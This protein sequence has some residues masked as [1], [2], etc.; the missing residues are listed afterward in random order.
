[1]TTTLAERLGHSP[2]DK[3]VIVSCDDLGA[4]HV[5]NLGVYAALRE[6]AA[7]CASLM[8]PAPWARH[9]VAEYRGEDVGV[10]WVKGH[11]DHACL[12]RGSITRYNTS[13]SKFIIT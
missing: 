3:L 13:T 2:N 4:F 9:A 1:M 5:A 6:G 7:T 10:Q 12:N 8:V 11:G